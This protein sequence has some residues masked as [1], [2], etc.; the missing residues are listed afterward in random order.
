MLLIQVSWFEVIVF[1]GGLILKEA[2]LY[3]ARSLA[4]L[5]VMLGCLFVSCVMHKSGWRI[6]SAINLIQ[7]DY[8]GLQISII[9]FCF[10]VLTGCH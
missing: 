1:I 5:L 3:L 10:Y 8:S 4:F 2:S 6:D 7:S 9:G